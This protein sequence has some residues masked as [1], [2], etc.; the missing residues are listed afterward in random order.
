MTT[1]GI[2]VKRKAL[3]LAEDAWSTCGHVAFRSKPIQKKKDVPRKQ[4]KKAEAYEIK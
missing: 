3:Q 4:P 1:L 2:I